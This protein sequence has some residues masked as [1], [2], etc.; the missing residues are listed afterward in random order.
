MR[1][2]LFAFALLGCGTTIYQVAP[3]PPDAPAPDTSVDAATVDA[4]TAD[5]ATVDAEIGRASCRERV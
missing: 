3:P 5:A 4:A 1:Y 2:A